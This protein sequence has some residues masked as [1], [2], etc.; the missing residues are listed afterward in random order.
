M[1]NDGK[2]WKTMEYDGTRW[3]TME[4]DGILP[5][6]HRW[7]TI[8]TPWNSNCNTVGLLLEFRWNPSPPYG[9]DLVF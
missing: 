5:T 2:R 8:V 6:E 3:N 1:E 4:N 9:P 7:I